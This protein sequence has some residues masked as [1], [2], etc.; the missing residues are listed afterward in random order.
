MAN[1]TMKLAAIFILLGVFVLGGCYYDDVLPPTEEEI[2]TEMSFTNDIIPIFNKDCNT[3]GC[4]NTGGQRPDLTPSRAYLSLTTASYLNT[5]SPEKSDLYLWMKG[6]KT[7]PMPVTGSI[8]SNNAKV[9]AWIKQGIK[10][11]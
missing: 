3:S 6:S 2:T 4:H 8:P 9:L 1:S 11:N 7:L 10:N 5:A